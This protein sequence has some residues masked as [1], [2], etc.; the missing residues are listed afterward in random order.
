MRSVGLPTGGQLVSLLV[1]RLLH[2][3]AYWAARSN[4]I[5]PILLD[6]ATAQLGCP[7]LDLS[8]CGVCIITNGPLFGGALDGSLVWFGH[9]MP[10]GGFFAW[11]YAATEPL[12]MFGGQCLIH[13]SS[14]GSELLR[15]LHASGR[16]SNWILL[17][18]SG[19]ELLRRLDVARYVSG[20][21]FI[22]I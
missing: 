16:Y 10:A 14:H 8:Y 19:S 22:W 11:P 12:R 18:Y 21:G 7:I 6:L 3:R 13:A 20:L 2:L 4:R 17:S 9:P 15:S 5:L 1:W